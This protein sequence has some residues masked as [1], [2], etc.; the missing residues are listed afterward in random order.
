MASRDEL[1]KYITERVV[2]YIDTPEKNNE[3]SNE[4]M[5]KFFPAEPWKVKWFG[6]MPFSLQMWATK[7]I[8]RVNAWRKKDGS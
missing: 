7:H 1:I 6:F 5:P 2:E 3:R 8:N 4:P